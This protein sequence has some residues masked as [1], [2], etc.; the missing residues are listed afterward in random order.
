MAPTRLV[1]P[2]A[3]TV[4]STGERLAEP[5]PPSRDGGQHPHTSD[6]VTLNEAGELIAAAEAGVD[7]RTEQRT[8]PAASPA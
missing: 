7:S 8:E 2:R 3:A 1:C 5:R 4:D 6:D